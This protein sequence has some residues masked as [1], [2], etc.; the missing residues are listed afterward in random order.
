VPAVVVEPGDPRSHP[1]FIGNKKRRPQV[2]VD[3]QRP[4][5]TAQ[6]SGFAAERNFFEIAQLLRPATKLTQITSCRYY[7]HR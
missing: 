1:N 3:A 7:A 5:M 4:S 6:K 2:V